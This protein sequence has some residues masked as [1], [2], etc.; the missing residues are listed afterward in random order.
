VGLGCNGGSA[1]KAGFAKV[2]DDESIIEVTPKVVAVKPTATDS[3]AED[4]LVNLIL[5]H[6]GNAPSALDAFRTV[7]IRRTGEMNAGGGTMMAAECTD[8]IAWPNGFRADFR[9]QGQAMMSFA[10]WDNKHWQHAPLFG[11]E[12]KPIDEVDLLRVIPEK[13]ATMLALLTPLA[14][15]SGRVAMTVPDAEMPKGLRGVRVWVREMAP[16]VL[17]IDS[18]TGLLN[19]VYYDKVELG[20]KSTWMFELK[21]MEAV[22]GVKLPKT[23]KFSSGSLNGGEWSKIEYESTAQ[24]PQSIFEKP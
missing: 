14:E 11:A 6:T 1:S 19:R 2:I 5:A 8:R 15:T 3:A 21:S 16:M 12:A 4:T 20:R 17:A 7:T 23:I 10:F 24:H 9:M 22:N 18:K 13:D